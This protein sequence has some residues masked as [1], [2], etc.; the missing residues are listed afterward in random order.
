MAYKTLIFG[1]DDLFDK[2][3]PHYEREIQ[4]GTF[5]IVAQAVVE[6]DEIFFFTPDGKQITDGDLDID[7]AVISSGQNFYRRM[8]L[9]ESMGL[10]HDRIIDGRV[11]QVP[12]LDFPRLLDEGI[13]YGSF[14]KIFIQANSYTVYP[15]VYNIAAI[16]TK[17]TLG[18]KSYFEKI[19]AHCFNA[20]IAIEDFSSVSWSVIF[21]VG[22]NLDHNRRNVNSYGLTHLDWSAPKEFNPPKGTCQI[23]IGNDVWIGR[24]S[25]LKC[26][27]PDKPLII[28]DGAVV[29]SDSV[30]VKSVPPYAIVGGNPAQII[31]YRFK[32]HVIESLLRIK[33]WDWSLDKI[34]E[35]FRH[36]NDV[37]KFIAL[38]D[39][40]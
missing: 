40:S 39:R 33:W 27:N 1:T 29:A 4:R 36:F 38:H 37:E 19:T 8:K 9:L 14:D 28:G 25:T 23:F 32:P 31:K 13:A 7:I 6:D 12:N 15:Q 10:P 21:E 22:L 34:Y 26:T 17:I 24:G 20:E 18:R 3:R 30:V 16:K 2:L 35:N 11:L 5:D